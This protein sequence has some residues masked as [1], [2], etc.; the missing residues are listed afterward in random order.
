[1][2]EGEPKLLEPKWQRTRAT[3]AVQG[4]IGHHLGVPGGCPL[5][6]PKDSVFKCSW[7]HLGGVFWGV[8]GR[9]LGDPGSRLGP[10]FEI[11]GVPWIPIGPHLGVPGGCPLDCPK[12]SVFK[13]Y[14]DHL[15]GVFWG[16]PGRSLGDPGSRLGSI[17]EILG[18]P[19][20][21]FGGPWGFPARLSQR[22]RFQVLLGPSRRRLL[23]LG[24]S[25][26]L[27]VSLI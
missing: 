18:V 24:I 7:D 9:S 14:W 26:S 13:C 23:G 8:P 17:F 12:D 20:I 5:D 3:L 4:S 16:G 6:C 19:W 21:P 27:G 15:G 25:W 1:M 2:A 11:L 10:I 22:L